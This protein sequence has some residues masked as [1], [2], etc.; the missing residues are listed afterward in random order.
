MKNKIKLLL[1]SSLLLILSSCDRLDDNPIFPDD[2]SGK[3]SNKS[4]Q[5]IPSLSWLGTPHGILATISFDQVI[6]GFTINY[7]MGYAQFGTTNSLDAGIVTVNSNSLSKYTGNAIYYSS[8]NP[9]SP[10]TL[11]GVNFN[12]S[13]H[14]WSVGGKNSVPQF[15][16]VV[17]SPHEFDLNYPL[18][19]ATVSKTADLNITWDLTGGSADSVVVFLTPT[20]GT[21]TPYTSSVLKNTGTMKIPASE[22]AKFS[23]SVVLQVV[24][25]R[26]TY[27]TANNKLYLAVAEIVKSSFLTIN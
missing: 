7:V 27:T 4:G 20:S 24:K 19:G 16:L 18:S 6:S 17:S 12:G 21:S 1:T 5:P 22:V 14:N 13:A 11:T 3:V 9:N 15:D 26:Y 25:F 23:G 2:T 10:S 8:F